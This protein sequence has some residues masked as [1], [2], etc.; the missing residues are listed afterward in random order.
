MKQSFTARWISELLKTWIGLNISPP[1][2][3][4]IQ[5]EPISIPI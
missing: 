1:T 4:E 2:L 5:T 3:R